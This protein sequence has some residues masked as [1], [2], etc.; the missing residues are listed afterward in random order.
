[1][2][3]KYSFW[4]SGN[5][6]KENMVMVVEVANVRLDLVTAIWRKRRRRKGSDGWVCSGGKKMLADHGTHEG[7]SAR[8][9]L[10]IVKT[11]RKEDV[12]RMGY[13][14]ILSFECNLKEFFCMA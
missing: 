2:E 7:A 12:D 9:M 4:D 6:K 13:K 11:G 3:V 1:M 5:D 14:I 10:E 8:A